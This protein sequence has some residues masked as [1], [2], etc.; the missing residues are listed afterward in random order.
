MALVE[1]NIPEVGG[2]LPREVREFLAEAD[3]RIEQFLH[4]ARAPAFVPSDHDGAYRALKGIVDSGA[5]RGSMFCEW[6][7]G[8]GV[9]TGLAAFL[10]YEAY[11]IEVE[12]E[13]VNHSRGLAEDFGLRAE[14]VHGSFV[15]R[16]GEDR[17]HTS[18][19][20]SWLTTEGDYAYDEMGLDA[21]DFDVVFAYPWPDEEGVVAD[22][23]DRYGG[24]GAV[25]VTY[26]GGT[27]FR[28]RRKRP[29]K[30]R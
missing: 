3:R 15:P 8:F 12:G 11:G 23:F 21:D 20:Y 30:R 19:P 17:I 6:G 4:T 27:E 9:I 13:L 5:A 29:R 28:V 25:L 14:F 10:G 24:E 26:H 7:S 2:A 22:L 1:V 16:G 18:G